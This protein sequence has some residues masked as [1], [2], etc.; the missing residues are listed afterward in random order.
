MAFLRKITRNRDQITALLM[1]LPSVI[2]IAVFV[3]GFIGQTAYSSMTDWTGVS[4]DQKNNFV[5]L[6]NY[7][8]LFTSLL[9][10]R[11]RQSLVNTMFFTVFFIAGCLTL[12]LLF[13]ILIDS[14]IR[15]EGVFR[16]IFLY[17]MS[18]S[19]IVTGT[20]WRWLFNPIGGINRLPTLFNLE[21]WKVKWITD[22]TQ[23]WQFDWVLIPKILGY[24]ILVL[25]IYLAIRSWKNEH[26]K[27]AITMSVLGI[28]TLGWL[29][30]G[31][32]DNLIQMK[33]PEPHGFNL[34]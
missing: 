9:D 12:G 17:P 22:R 6:D 14:G 11:F 4:L 29:L 1:L 5:G 30:A 31:G 16:I 7:V 21:P 32:A 33:Y 26:T 27:S 10:V 8:K 13:A 20:V 25:F 23:I 34:A 18:L 2:L 19:F 28:L 15:Y 3:Y 24:T